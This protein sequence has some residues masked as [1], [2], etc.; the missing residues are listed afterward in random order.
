MKML[1]VEDETAA[2]RNLVKIVH[3]IDHT[4]EIAG[5][6]ES[7]Q[8]T[9]LWLQHHPA[10]D[11]ILMDIHLSD[12]SAFNIFG[13]VT[14]ETPIV[15]TTA[16]D[17]YAID[18]FR[19]NSI[20]YLLKPIEPNEVKRA[21]D[22][23]KRLNSRD[24]LHY[25]TGLSRLIPTGKFPEK[26]LITQND[27]LIPVPVK[28]IA[29]FYNTCE[30]TTV[31]LKDGRSYPYNRALDPIMQSLNPA[32]FYRANKQFIIAKEYVK[33]LTVWFDSRLLITLSVEPPEKIYVSK[34]RAAAFKQWIIL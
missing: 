7:V 21:L 3:E 6:T 11:L 26:I 23:F 18:A 2:A 27:K 15:F 31:F 4:I 25:A 16:Y 29:C 19:V 20:D 10:P 9:V 30:K 28:E 17:E 33:D 24:R 1:I 14:V 34:N 5:Q 13:S 12:G 8:Q 32:D 22:K